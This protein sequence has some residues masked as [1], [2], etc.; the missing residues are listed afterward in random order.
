MKNLLTISYFIVILSL[1][2]GYWILKVPPKVQAFERPP[3]PPRE[4]QIEVIKHWNE[5]KIV[6]AIKKKFPEHPELFVKIANCESTLKPDA[7]NQDTNDGGI[8]Q[9]S[10][11]Y[12]GKEMKRLG[13]DRFNVDDNLKYARILYEKNGTKDW[14]AS[15]FCWSK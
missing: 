10:E 5:E 14:S 1:I 13:I 12:H 11:Q 3:E 7:Y 9:L 8:F 6:D 15:K 4:V 2:L